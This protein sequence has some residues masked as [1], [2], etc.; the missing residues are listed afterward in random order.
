MWR[1]KK[2][3]KNITLYFCSIPIRFATEVIEILSLAALGFQLSLRY[4]VF[5]QRFWV[6]WWRRVEVV[7]LILTTIDCI[8]AFTDE[9]WVRYSRILRIFFV[10]NQNHSTRNHFSKVLLTLFNLTPVLIVLVGWVCLW[11]I[12]AYSLFSGVVEEEKYPG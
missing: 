2:K 12:G 1:K 5:S 4:M 8:G 6:S 9:T 10:F 7:V 3:K 11:A